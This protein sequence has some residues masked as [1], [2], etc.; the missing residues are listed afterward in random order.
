MARPPAGAYAHAG[1]TSRGD[2]EIRLELAA[3]LSC[4]TALMLPCSRALLAACPGFAKN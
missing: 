1:E 2:W 3:L 4:S